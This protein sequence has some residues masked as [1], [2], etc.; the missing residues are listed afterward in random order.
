MNRSYLYLLVALNVV[1]G[2]GQSLPFGSSIENELT[3]H[4]LDVESG[5]PNNII[6]DIEQD[7]LGFIWIATSDGLSRYDGTHFHNFI[8]A[9]S[10]VSNN[11][12][13][14][15][16]Q[17]IRFNDKGE[18]FI[19]TSKGL[20]IYNQKQEKFN[21]FN[22]N[23]GL[24]GN[25][26]SCFDFGNG[27]EFFVGANYEGVQMG[28]D[29]LWFDS[30]SHNPD[31]KNSLS[32]NEI[33]SIEVQGDTT[34]WIGTFNKGLNKMNYK[35]KEIIRIPFGENKSINSLR[36]NTLYE[37]RNG[38][39]WVGSSKGLHVITVKGDTLRL[40]ESSDYGIGLSDNNVLCFEEDKVG[41]IWVG[42][43]NG[44]LNVFNKLDFLN[45][46]SNFSVKW[47]LPSND[48]SSVFNRTVSSLKLDL[49]GNMWIG[50]ATGLNF[51]NPYGEAVKLLQRNITRSETL[52]HNRIGALYESYT[53]EIWVGTDGSGLDLLD[54]KTKK[55]KHYL[56]DSKK[57]FSISSNYV[58]SLLEDT[59]KRLWVG[60]FRGGLN[61]MDLSTGHFKYY[62]QGE[63]DKGSDVRI[64]Y[65]DSKG[66]IWVGTNRGGLYK[67]IESKDE[68][69][70]IALLE[71]ID[72]RDISEDKKGNLW[73]STYG[74]GILKY[75]PIS[76]E[77]V[78]YNST[79]LENFP[80]DIIFS[81]HCLPD[82][83]I[84][85]GTSQEGLIRFNPEK[86]TIINYTEKD[87][88]SNNT[89]S[90]IIIGNESDI[91]LGTFKGI[92]H[93]DPKT[94]KIYNLNTYNNIQ[95]SVFNI[96]SAI[97]SKSGNL[98]FGGNKGLNFFNPINFQNKKEYSPIIFKGLE[99]FNK[100][101]S[102]GYGD[103]KGI[104]NQ[105]LLYQDHIVLNHNHTLFSVNF[106]TIKY[107]S[108]KN[109]VYSYRL[110]NYHDDWINASGI[111]KA[112][113]ANIP[114]GSY[115]LNVKAKFGS[116]D[117]LYEKLKITI[118]P[119]F[120]QTPLAYFIYL[121]LILLSLWGVF[122]YYSE[123]IK[124]VNSL[125]FEKKQRQLE[126]DFNEERIRFFT[127]F[128]HELKTPLTLIIAP[129]ED[130]MSE[131]S[132]K[133]NQEKLLLVYK[134]SN[135]L[136]QSISRLLEFR[137]SNLG[138]SKLRI[139]EYDLS[140][141]LER[142]VQNYLPLAKNNKV[143]LT[144][145]IPEN[146]IAWFD[147][148]K[149]EII[150]NNLISNA[151]KYSDKKGEIH[152][153]L[154]YDASFF[155]IK[156]KDKGHGIHHK[157][158]SHVF[159]WYYKSETV[160]K[161]S[162]TGIGLALTKNFVEL[163]NGE[164]S[165]KSN[166]NT[167]S[168]FIV[169]IPRDKELFVNAI[170]VSKHSQEI[171]DKKEFE[172]LKEDTGII[173]FASNEKAIVNIH[174][175]KNSEVI[176]LID[177]NSDI[178][179]YLKGLLDSKYDLLFANDGK[180]GVEKAVRCVPD[181]IISDVMMPEMNG[182][183]L[184]NTLKRRVETNHI[185]IILLTAKDNVESIELG[186]EEGADDYII[187]PFNSQLLQSR[188]RNILNSRVQLRKCFL[189]EEDQLTEIPNDKS[190]LIN[191]EKEFLN[192][193]EKVILIQ[194]TQE[195]T[196]VNVISQSIGM[197][198][199]SLFRKIKAITGLNINQYVRRVKLNRAL[200]IIKS[201][202]TTISQVSYEVGFANIKYF[203][204]LF[205]EQFGMLPSEVLKKNKR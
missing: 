167:G 166:I 137:K 94:N 101:V 120:W 53:G 41:Q 47:Y 128:S 73:I 146:F 46:N 21:L 125:I 205:K 44:G 66:I 158:I 8:E 78:F 198:R 168:T 201:G 136:F 27:Q 6:N 113:L 19:G 85:A 173:N 54:P 110:D 151:I 70:F 69:K 16:I 42:T 76:N 149:L 203:R 121:A 31:N 124:L 122:K 143:S 83:S 153:T 9:D 30:Y 172:L 152:L 141:C 79:N 33:S 148:E 90:S 56:H 82:G 187:K 96:G 20:N 67:Y 75:E 7:S 142:W 181:L 48:G 118:K 185:P 87:G 37:E 88:L 84:L 150:V 154:T 106:V 179:K 193:L 191:K 192:R 197:S 98:Y 55:V 52:G 35:T 145:N 114:P 183:E 24:L 176:L 144:F 28:N 104:L 102:V 200:E 59:K 10:L 160:T 77:V 177:D 89:V 91:W 159:D 80:T 204:K 117:E 40:E 147:I 63:I 29:S 115:L 18:L 119:P 140:S 25:N 196:N 51:V 188:I 105:S 133:K 130:L 180:E 178:L 65:E 71:K 156:V 169:K 72:I 107:P 186:Y 45:Q 164:I 23:N 135:I 139:E 134:N 57:P 111:G 17:T 15:Y 93:Y 155:K 163:H 129:L 49:E 81:I 36:I 74:D 43:R 131:L 3:F 86:E 184:C 162:G 127:S 170:I 103:K 190:K 171:K 199:T 34:I 126:H 132:S 11:I 109:I 39:L 61:K 92:S 112:K 189:S 14:N 62:L 38:N 95:Q 58:I 116:G 13:D 12:A 157:E 68:F 165:V 161:K 182:I 202:N 32:S 26:I 195:D 2:Y 1:F 5:L 100:K 194:L 50:T 138:L 64:I 123:R 99:V 108:V 175:D 60:T 22:R 97:R 174:N 4:L